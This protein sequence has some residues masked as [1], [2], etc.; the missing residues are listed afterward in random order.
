MLGSWWQ[1][2]SDLL[3]GKPKPDGEVLVKYCWTIPKG[4][5]SSVIENGLNCFLRE[6][7]D[8]P[9][10]LAAPKASTP[11][12][13][14]V[15]QKSI[16]RWLLVFACIFLCLFPGAV[17]LLVLKLSFDVSSRAPSDFSGLVTRNPAYEPRKISDL[18][19]VQ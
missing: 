8:R 2:V 14:L 10:P 12:L 13:S 9:Q 1:P 6:R 7:F 5:L 17:T 15:V 16:K 19:L 4:C 3:D 18:L 11:I